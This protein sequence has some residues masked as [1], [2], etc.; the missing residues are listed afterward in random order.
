M[1]TS[2]IPTE[3]CFADPIL[4]SQG[5]T[6]SANANGGITA[7]LSSFEGPHWGLTISG[8]YYVALHRQTGKIDGLYYDP[9]SQPY[10]NLRMVPDGMPLPRPDGTDEPM[11]GADAQ[12]QIKQ[13]EVEAEVEIKMEADDSGGVKIKQEPDDDDL[14]KKAGILQMDVDMTD[15]RAS[16]RR[17]YHKIRNDA[18]LRKWFPAVEFR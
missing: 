16:D 14:E 2:D 12:S 4:S 11:E 8:F 15:A 1:L 10:Q 18:P 6:S 9:G 13:E 7:S 3:R 17:L 5:G